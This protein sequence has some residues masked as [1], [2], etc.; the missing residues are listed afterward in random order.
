MADPLLPTPASSPLLHLTHPPPPGLKEEAYKGCATPTFQLLFPASYLLSTYSAPADVTP[1]VPSS[2]SACQTFCQ[3]QNSKPN[4]QDH[5]Y[6]NDSSKFISRPD[7]SAILFPHPVLSAGLQQL[8]CLP[9]PVLQPK[10]PCQLHTMHSL[11][12]PSHFDGLP[13]ALSISTHRNANQPSELNSN[14]P[15]SSVFPHHPTQHHSSE[16]LLS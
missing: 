10:G 1:E 16:F 11:S 2:P 4:F 6:A 15:S 14:D 7:L 9:A 3:T 12:Y 13:P 5:F 8:R